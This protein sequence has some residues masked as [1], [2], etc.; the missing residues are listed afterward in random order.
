MCSLPFLPPR[1]PPADP[2]VSYSGQPLSCLTHVPK[3][4]SGPPSSPQYSPS[5]P[6]FFPRSCGFLGRCKDH[7]LLGASGPGEWG[8]LSSCS[9]RDLLPLTFWASRSGS[10]GGRTPQIPQK[11][12]V[13]RALSMEHQM[14]FLSLLRVLPVAPSELVQADRCGVFCSQDW[15]FN[16][17]CLL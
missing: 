17:F 7:A 2:S 5:Q 1:P 15:D 11:L 12:F 14:L 6:S 13:P 3:E 10:Y 9:L 8:C 4:T 16:Y